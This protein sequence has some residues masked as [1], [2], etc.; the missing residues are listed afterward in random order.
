VI[1]L[2]SVELILKLS[3][4]AGWRSRWG[5]TSEGHEGYPVGIRREMESCRG[6]GILLTKFGTIS[7][8]T[9]REDTARESEKNGKKEALIFRWDV[10]GGD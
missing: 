7:I 4:A 9:L 5:F 2:K 1:V 10:R 3:K 6:G 8:P